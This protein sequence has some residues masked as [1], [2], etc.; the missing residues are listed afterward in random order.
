[1][2]YTETLIVVT[3]QNKDKLQKHSELINI[4]KITHSYTT[5]H[6]T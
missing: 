6:V 5:Y 1:M 2:K 4:G 3:M